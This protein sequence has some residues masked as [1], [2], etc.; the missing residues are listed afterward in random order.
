MDERKTKNER[1]EARDA[2]RRDA[3]AWGIGN[4][5]PGENARPGENGKAGPATR[6]NGVDRADLPNLAPV[7]L[8][9]LRRP[10]RSPVWGVS[11]GEIIDQ[12]ARPPAPNT[13]EWYRLACALPQR[14]PSGANL[15][16]VAEERSRAE[17]DYAYVLASLG[18]CVRSSS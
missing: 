6:V 12:A 18:P 10:G 13:L 5:R 17:R 15:S 3:P 1:A 14:L 4:G 9:V 7:S 8:T 16:R 11:W 2:A